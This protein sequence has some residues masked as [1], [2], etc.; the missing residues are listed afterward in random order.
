MRDLHAFF[1][2]FVVCDRLLLPVESRTDLGFDIL[3]WPRN[4]MPNNTVAIF[5]T[6]EGKR[7]IIVRVDAK[8]S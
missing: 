1:V 6:K 8:D 3:A 2:F 7:I 5:T 4:E